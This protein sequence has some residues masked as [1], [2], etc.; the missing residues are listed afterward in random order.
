MYEMSYSIPDLL[1]ESTVKEL[2]TLRDAVDHF[3]AELIASSTV[4]AI[5]LSEQA[6]GGST[7]LA[8]LDEAIATW[9]LISLLHTT[10]STLELLRLS[11]DYESWRNSTPEEML[12]WLVRRAKSIHSDWHFLVHS[13]GNPKGKKD[14]IDILGRLCEKVSCVQACLVS[15][16]RRDYKHS[17]EVAKRRALILSTLRERGPS[18]AS[19]LVEEIGETPWVTMERHY[20]NLI[21]PDGHKEFKACIGH[22]ISITAHLPAP[23]VTNDL[24]ALEKKGLVTS[25]PLDN[26]R[27]VMWFAVAQEHDGPK[28]TLPQGRR[29][30]RC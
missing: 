6:K 19:D 26:G 16:S 12:A 13:K 2:A 27:H 23:T 4:T 9:N 25:A 20:E 1:S 21:Y 22:L 5:N 15:I 14:F 7:D 3:A 10:R 11:C 24:K 18:R 29:R 17:G 30:A 28:A 8:I